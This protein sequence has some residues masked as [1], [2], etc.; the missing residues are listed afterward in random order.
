MLTNMGI[1][2]LKIYILQAHH[3]GILILVGMILITTSNESPLS[4]VGGRTGEANL[5]HGA[6]EVIV[7]VCDQ[8]VLIDLHA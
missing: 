7:E 3:E 8:C 4:K 6:R 5:G 1:S 2:S